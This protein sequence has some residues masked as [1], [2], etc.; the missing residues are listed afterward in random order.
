M[1][2]TVYGLPYVILSNK[3][4]KQRATVHFPVLF[5]ELQ[6]ILQK[7]QTKTAQKWYQ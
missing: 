2:Y 4:K 6:S 7:I 5:N 3:H 1:K